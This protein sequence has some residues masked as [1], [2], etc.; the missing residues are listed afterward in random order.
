MSESNPIH[1]QQPATQ[2][3]AYTSE[4]VNR[5]QYVLEPEHPIVSI[6]DA[7]ATYGFNGSVLAVLTLPVQ[8]AGDMPQQIGVI[9]YGEE[10]DG[11][12]TPLAMINGEPLIHLFGY[13]KSRFGLQPLSA[14]SD[15]MVG[16]SEIPE[17]QPG[18]YNNGFDTYGRA[19]YER[20]PSIT[21]NSYNL[22]INTE[23][24]ALS[25]GHFSAKRE[26]NAEGKPQI[27]LAVHSTNANK[28]DYMKQMALDNA[29]ETKEHPVSTRAVKI[30]GSS[31]VAQQAPRVDDGTDG[32]GLITHIPKF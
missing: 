6:E 4:L 13:A 11:G 30:L 27:L 18:D 22:G 23:N 19:G 31:A 2:E 5:G 24:M 26:R 16:Y 25:A 15:R 9:D 32:N 29:T 3:Y 20:D 17:A 1:N 8:R 21:R 14:P 28:L 7:Q 10:A 12:T